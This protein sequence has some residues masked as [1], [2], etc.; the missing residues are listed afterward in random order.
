MH[1]RDPVQ[2]QAVNAASVFLKRGDAAVW[3]MQVGAT[4]C[5]IPNQGLK[6]IPVLFSSHSHGIQCAHQQMEGLIKGTA[7]V[8]FFISKKRRFW[9]LW[10]SMRCC[11]R[12][13][14]DVHL[15]AFEGM[16]LCGV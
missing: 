6:N 3:T 1:C 5:D 14:I 16:N 11:E 9:E 15:A 2:P 4:S 8:C 12:I 7:S 10:L 13:Q